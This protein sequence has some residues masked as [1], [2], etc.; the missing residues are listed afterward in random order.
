[1]VLI[2][3]IATVLLA[4][5][6]LPPYPEIWKRNGRVVGISKFYI[7]IVNSDLTFVEQFCIFFLP[8]P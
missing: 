6:I 4:L 2:G 3:S 8:P 5:G 1:M 7:L